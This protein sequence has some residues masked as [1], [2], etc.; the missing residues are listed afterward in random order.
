MNPISGYRHFKVHTEIPSRHNNSPRNKFY[1]DTMSSK[2]TKVEESPKTTSAKAPALLPTATPHRQQVLDLT[3]GAR[4]VTEPN[5]PNQNFTWTKQKSWNHTPS[6]EHSLEKTQRGATK[7][8]TI[9]HQLP[10]QKSPLQRF[11]QSSILKGPKHW[12]NPKR[13]HSHASLSTKD[14]NH[15]GY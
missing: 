12:F 2:R 1:A 10:P 5:S 8:R 13:L 4:L 15:E 7:N 14:L 3:Y 6:A 11:T 9:K